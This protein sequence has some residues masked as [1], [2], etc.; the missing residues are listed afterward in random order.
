MDSTL[1]SNYT[2]ALKFQKQ[3]YYIVNNM[4]KGECF[5]KETGTRMIWTKTKGE[6][7]NYVN[8]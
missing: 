5:L 7:D 1:N 8:I 6:K 3:K 2:N 4:N